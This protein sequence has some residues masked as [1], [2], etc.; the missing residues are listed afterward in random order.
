MDMFSLGMLIVAKLLEHDFH[1][2]AMEA[3][4]CSE[5]IFSLFFETYTYITVHPPSPV[6]I[7]VKGTPEAN[8]Y[9]TPYNLF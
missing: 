7:A 4:L 5:R 3:G 1:G 8:K 2:C 6:H 9:Q